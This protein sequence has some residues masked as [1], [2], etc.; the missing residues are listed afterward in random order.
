MR[1]F[2]PL[3]AIACVLLLAGPS[4]AN[5]M[6][7]IR[8]AWLKRQQAVKYARFFVRDVHTVGAGTQPG[9]EITGKVDLK[10]RKPTPPKDATHTIKRT[11]CLQDQ[12]LRST[13]YGRFWHAWK[14][15]FLTLD[16]RM[17]ITPG[18]RTTLNNWASPRS[19]VRLD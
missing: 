3:P 14:E 15:A 18:R 8:T 12:S 4:D 11:L 6:A 7:A 19:L 10:G 1:D 13:A 2:L 5:D 17:L 16:Q 9:R